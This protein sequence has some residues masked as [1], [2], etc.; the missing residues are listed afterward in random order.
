MFCGENG[1][2]LDVKSLSYV[3]SFSFPFN[4]LSIKIFAAFLA[5][6]LCKAC[7]LLS[8]DNVVLKM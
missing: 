3:P 8:H 2:M 4:I 7:L 6:C 5:T 1:M